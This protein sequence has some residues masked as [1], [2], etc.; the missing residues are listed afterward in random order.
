MLRFVLLLALFCAL[1]CSK[2]P[3]PT[4]SAGKHPSGK[5]SSED[6]VRGKVDSPTGLQATF[7]GTE[8]S[9]AILLSWS[10]PGNTEG[11]TGEYNIRFKKSSSLYYRSYSTSSLSYRVSGLEMGDVYDW[12]VQT[13]A[14]TFQGWEHSDW[15]ES[16]FTV[17]LPEIFIP[18][19]ALR[20]S[21]EQALGKNSGDM[22]TQADIDS[23]RSLS[24]KNLGI[25]DLR[26][27][28]AAKNLIWVNIDS[29]RVSDL[30]PLSGL[31]NLEFLAFGNNRVSDLTP[32]SGLTKLEFLDF[33]GNQ[34]SDIT[35]LS[36]L[37]NL[38]QLDFS[39]NRVSDITSL[40]DLTNLQLLAFSINQVSDITPLTS[41][42]NLQRVFFSRN[43]VSD[44]SPLVA[45]LSLE[46]LEAQNNPLSKVSI[47]V[48]IPKLQSRSVDVSIASSLPFA[49]I[50][51]SFN[52]DLVFL[53]DFIEEEREIWHYA[54]KR[55]ESAIQTGHPDYTF[56]EA[57][58]GTCGDQSINI[59]EGE[60]ID[61]LRIYVTKSNDGYRLSGTP[62]VLHASSLPLI[63]CIQVSPLFSY[64]FQVIEGVGLHKIGHVL[65]IGTIWH[66]SGMLRDLS[67]D[68]HFAGP[69]AIA[70]FDR[71]GGTDYQ[72][73]KVPITRDG[74]HWRSSVLTGELMT[75]TRR[76]A[77]SAFSAITLQAL[78]DLGYSVDLSTA[79]P[80]VLPLPTAAKS[81]ADEANE[82]LEFFCTL[83][84]LPAPVYL[85]D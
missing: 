7:D 74:L 25:K 72:D 35:S 54:A 38:Q 24:M 39:I 27:L 49:E 22:L 41:M 57:W 6:E 66:D 60:Q 80:Y 65:G 13:E 70:A 48:H 34:V 21:I 52:I 2:E 75:F 26:G 67:G 1:S 59:I 44:L 5:I 73:A 78:S 61:D 63:G 43:N 33:S 29:N 37:T 55:W 12:E 46:H 23:L 30:T 79:D 68:A 85:D 56:S 17:Q 20:T 8:D 4:A 77:D 3:P 45:L 69:Q 71:A 18:D 76:I 83:E 32:L 9:P 16:I 19:P 31:T 82:E 14:F 84:G 64:S 28:E 81:V 15:V 50:E 42:P 10:P 58:S 47:D 36:D 11:T 53:G 40:S 62:M 51:S